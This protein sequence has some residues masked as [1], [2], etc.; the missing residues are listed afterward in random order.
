M[1]VGSG[2]EPATAKTGPGGGSGVCYAATAT[3][4]ATRQLDPSA[5]TTAVAEDNSRRSGCP[6]RE[7]HPGLGRWPRIAGCGLS[8]VWHTGS[9]SR[10]YPWAS[11]RARTLEPQVFG[12][13]GRRAAGPARPAG[14]AGPVRRLAGRAGVGRR[15]G[16]RRRLRRRPGLHRAAG[17][18]SA[19]RPGRPGGVAVVPARASGAGRRAP[20]RSHPMIVSLLCSRRRD[21][22]RLPR[23]CSPSSL[24]PLTPTSSPAPATADP[25]RT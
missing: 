10:R 21:L 16:C 12:G 8:V 25:E 18:G 14:A 7:H 3:P 24:A 19:G 11:R 22:S 17:P 5:A 1:P 13:A 15:R 20:L 9:R 2:S 6:G 4:L 23:F